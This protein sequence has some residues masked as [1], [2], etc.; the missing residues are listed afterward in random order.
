VDNLEPASTRCCTSRRRGRAYLGS[1]A[2]VDQVL[3]ASPPRLSESDAVELARSLFGLA[4]ASACDLG[5]ERDR[6]FGLDD[7]EGMPAAILKVSNASEDPEVLDMEA[8]VALHVT[9]ADPGLGV[10][11]PW[12][13]ARTG[14]PGPARPGDR[15]EELRAPWRHAETTHWAR[16]YDVLP[17]RSRIEAAGLSDA[18]LV[19]WGETTARLDQPLRGFTHPR[20][21]R[22][23]LW[24]VQ[25]SLESRAMLDDIRDE[26]ERGQVARVLDEFE[27]SVTPVWPRLRAQ[28]AHTDL[29][30]DNTLTDDAGLITG[31]IDFGDM[32]HTAMITELASVL[33][34]LG[35]GRDGAE[36]FRLA[37]LVLDGFQRR[38]ELEDLELEA[39]GVMWA[40]RSAVT[41]AISSWRVAQGLE[42][43]AF[44]ERYNAQ[45]ARMLAT[46]EEAG[47]TE[48][49]RQLG[50][51]VARGD[52]RSL[53]AR[54][55]AAFGPAM[56]A[57]FYDLPVEV[58]RAEGVWITDTDGRRYLDVYNNVPCVGHGHSRV[59]SAIARQG[60]RINT[61][62][63]YLH[64]AAIE[65]AE[66]LAGLCPAELDTVV[67]VNS[68]SE[69]NDLAWRMATAV[70]GRRGGLCTAYAY[71]GITEATA[72]LSP[73]SW[74]D[75]PPP[76]HVERWEPPDTY[77]GE[78]LDGGGFAAAADRLTARG[79][80][81]AAAILDG[82]VISDRIDD[83]DPAYVQDL[84]G[85]ARA[86][87]AL[88][89]A[90]EVQAGHG[91]TGAMWA[92][93]RF[94]VVPDFVTLGK[95]MGNGHP[96]A[97]VI[98][99][100][101]IAQALVGHT[102]LFST[103]GGNPVS[104]VAAV[105]VLDVIADER[106][107]D[108]VQVSG[109]ALREALHGLA[110]SHDAMGHIRGA[111]LAFGIEIVS[112]PAGRTPDG[113]R[114]RAVRDRARHH[115]VLI[116]TTG[117]AG[118]ILKLRPPLAFTAAH[119]PTLVSALDTALAETS[120]SG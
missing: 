74:F 85:R 106:V 60:R 56:E 59:T 112:D 42:E 93:D 119:V 50:A 27:R 98:T 65:L 109:R 32:S 7:A 19:A 55:A 97:A 117:R 21:R 95:P 63:R 62:M 120:P 23:M 11:V 99:R 43:Q 14:N 6:T 91:R 13:S 10:A 24:D 40:A 34:S 79:M 20:A 83:L 57:L 26:H 72:A 9:A 3:S 33:D 48:V 114:A 61:H 113:A 18:A 53:A 30:V 116:G 47:W 44:A 105:A 41:I 15:I 101:E 82:L 4:A 107:L 77:R 8:K 103:F 1:V 12:R 111:G 89:I 2:A 94:G 16:L 69:A 75:S 100:S 17:G 67:L 68:G 70:T 66:R 108:R 92:F 37:R 35:V 49:A 73:E 38:I 64:P 86:A 54:R 118:N 45:C 25:H 78:H 71:H 31:V 22:T 52:G 51:D 96:V 76:E 28:V 87:G 84:V 36:L 5:S 88:W 104:A 90:D 80:A 81:P 110:A 46:I 39:L 58:S 102:V 115:G 29:S